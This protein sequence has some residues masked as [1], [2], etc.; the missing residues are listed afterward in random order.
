MYYSEEEARALIIQ[1]GLELIEKKLI[2][3]TWGNISAR[4][5]ENTFL[6]TPSGRAYETLKPED[7][8]RVS[9]RDLSCSGPYKPSSEKGLHAAVYALRPDVCFIIHTHQPYASAV[10][11]EGE[12][13]PFAPCAQYALPGTE[14]LS[15]YTAQTVAAHP[16]NNAFLLAKH[17][18]VCLGR[19]Y[20]EAFSEADALEEKCKAL[21]A[22]R[23]AGKTKRGAFLDD[24]AQL[25]GFGMRS[26]PEDRE[27]EEM[28]RAKNAAAA[29]YVR[30]AKRMSFFDV[31]LQR[32]VYL[33]KY[34]RLKNR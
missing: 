34:S 14:K 7:I 8:S 3:R 13:T 29:A 19:T 15:A 1:A 28:V 4:L 32:A 6:I 22:E 24:Y 17:G 11:A 26:N 25:I 27:A 21:C 20:E 12:D 30:K 10:C 5:D 33:F 16:G 2:A 23:G 9:V 31:A 18:T